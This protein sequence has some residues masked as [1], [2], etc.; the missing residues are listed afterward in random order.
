MDAA[1]CS[2]SFMQTIY[3]SDAEI[4]FQSFGGNMHE[5][6]FNSKMKKK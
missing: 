6:F 5:D 3:T 2:Q 1:C 4:T